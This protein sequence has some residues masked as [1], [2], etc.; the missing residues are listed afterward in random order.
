MCGRYTLIAGGDA[1][2]EHFALESVPAL[3]PRYNI[4]PTQNVAV[5]RQP[6]KEMGRQLAWVRWGLIPSW[7][8]DVT[9]GYRLLN[10][11]SETVSTKP[12]FRAAFKQRR[13]LVPADG[14]YEWQKQGSRKQPYYFRRAD[15]RLFA[16]AGL[17]EHWQGAEGVIE[18]CTLLTMEANELLRP[19]HNRM[20]VI[21][22]EEHFDRWL[23]PNLTKTE[24][25]L[26]LLRPWPATDMTATAVQTLVNSPRN[27][28][29]ACIAP[30]EQGGL[31]ESAS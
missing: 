23:D 19:I 6:S 16:F 31:F 5:V 17:W 26:E 10:A 13:C 8:T 21:L 2:A 25:V 7:A 30:L 18:S 28:G 11:R 14:F 4:A 9:I 12:A 3:T 22:A 15:E 20:P 1:V 24:L 27:E 29:P